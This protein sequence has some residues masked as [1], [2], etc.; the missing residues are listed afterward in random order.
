MSK[1]IPI[2]RKVNCETPEDYRVELKVGDEVLDINGNFQPIGSYV[3]EEIRD[4][5]WIWGSRMK[6]PYYDGGKKNYTD[7]DISWKL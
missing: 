6:T 4:D 7:Y 1:K 5:G 2:T 3:I